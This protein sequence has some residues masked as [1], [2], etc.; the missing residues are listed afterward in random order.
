MGASTTRAKAAE[1]GELIELGAD[2]ID[3]VA[4]IG[5]IF[6]GDWDYVAASQPLDARNDP[7]TGYTDGAE[8]IFECLVTEAVDVGAGGLGPQ[9][10]MV[11]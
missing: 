4:P 11:D 8:S 10:C 3:M 1:A 6:V 7:A 2:E 5:R 9:K